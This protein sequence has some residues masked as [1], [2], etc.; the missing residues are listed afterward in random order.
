MKKIVL[1]GFIFLSSCKGA[2]WGLYNRDNYVK[3]SY[4]TREQILEYQTMN[5][6]V[7]TA[8]NKIKYNGNK[9][10]NKGYSSSRGIIL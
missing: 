4:W 3:G 2:E 9:K 10:F 8:I 5:P 1:I 7:H 6:A